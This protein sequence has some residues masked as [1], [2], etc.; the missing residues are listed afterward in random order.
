MIR[1]RYERL[2]RNWS[3]VVLSFHSGGVTTA[4]ISKIETGRLKPTKHCRERLARALGIDPATL[5][6]EVDQHAAVGA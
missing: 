2:T 5:L 4:E 1:M 3:Q 6:D